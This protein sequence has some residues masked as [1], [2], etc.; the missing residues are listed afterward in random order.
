VD[1]SR[2]P[3]RP[4]RAGAHRRRAAP[5]CAQA[6]GRDRP[7]RATAPPPG[8]PSSTAYGPRAELKP[9]RIIAK[10]LPQP[11]PVCPQPL[12]SRTTI[13]SRAP[14][15]PPKAREL[16]ISLA[17]Q[18]VQRVIHIPLAGRQKLLEPATKPLI[19]LIAVARAFDHE[20]KHRVVDQ[21]C[22]HSHPGSRRAP[23]ACSS[24]SI[25]AEKPHMLLETAQPYNIVKPSDPNGRRTISAVDVYFCVCFAHRN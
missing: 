11:Q 24:K 20:R 16:D 13:D 23:S 2:A 5:E 14:P 25:I 3:A 17:F 9:P 18:P 4:R 7:A 12:L 19:E 6:V 15:R 10:M 8:R 22:H 21:R 1:C